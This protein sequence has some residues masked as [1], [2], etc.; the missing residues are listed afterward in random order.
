MTNVS[1]TYFAFLLVFLAGSIAYNVYYYYPLNP[2]SDTWGYLSV[3]SGIIQEGHFSNLIDPIDVYYHP[4]PVMPIATSM[5]SSVTGLDLVVAVFVFPGVLVLL[6]PLLVFL[7]SRRIF[8]NSE[9]AILSALV[10]VTEATVV[11]GINNVQGTY[12][13]IS[14]SLLVL[15]MLFRD[16]PSRVNAILA[17][18]FFFV[19]AAAHGA[20]ALVLFVLI[21]Y[22]VLTVRKVYR[23]MLMLLGVI[24]CGYLTTTALISPFISRALILFNPL[25]TFTSGPS[26]L[27][28][29]YALGSSGML[30]VWW[31]LPAS[32]GLFSLLVLRRDRVNVWSLAGLSLLGL[33]YIGNVLSPD[34]SLDRYG[35]IPA[36]VILAVSGGKVL[37]ILARTRRRL[38]ILTLITVFVCFSAVIDPLLSPQYG[39]ATSLRLPPT[40]QD[41]IAL[42]LVNRYV[43]N[44]A[45]VVSDYYS[46]GYLTFIRYQSGDLSDAGIYHHRVETIT[47]MTPKTNVVLLV[48]WGY[49]GMVPTS[50]SCTGLVATL[51][52]QKVN[53][54][55]NNSCDILETHP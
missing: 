11:T 12:P 14:L 30:F 18:V 10:L 1:K 44:T 39:F 19:L 50:P 5:L 52:N 42:D 54:I 13:A 51:T 7:L 28:P 22:L 38:L 47:T 9:A 8:G 53:I 32:L 6:Q 25:F 40:N 15:I 36:W 24:F 48:R 29:L 27:P 37:T 23:G 33:S 31:G 49:T 43:P 2:E 45:V 4:F 55:Y 35:G 41:R 3:A 17:F 26:Y 34:L 21:A 20:V 46:L 16:P